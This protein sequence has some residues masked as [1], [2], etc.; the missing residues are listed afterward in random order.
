MTKVATTT[1]PNR[2]AKVAET[3]L[4]LRGSKAGVIA[5]LN[6]IAKMLG[7]RNWQEVNWETLNAT[8]VQELVLKVKGP[9]TVRKRILSLLKGVARSAWRSGVLDTEGL[10][11]INDLT[12]EDC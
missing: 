12:I 9:I 7:A 11:R 8:N 10:V 1:T 3:Y 6:K 5:D 4:V 2:G